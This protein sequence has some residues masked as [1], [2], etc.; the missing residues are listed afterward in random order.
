MRFAQKFYDSTAWHKCRRAYI[1]SVYGLCEICNAPGYIVHHKIRLTP[2]NINDQS[3]TLAFDNLQYVCL[4]C[5]NRIHMRSKCISDQI[6]FDDNGNVIKSNGV[7]NPN[8]NN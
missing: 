2:Y 4:D 1:T 6:D 7:N 3:V 8:G 5:H